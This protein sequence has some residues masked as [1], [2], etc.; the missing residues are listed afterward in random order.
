MRRLAALAIA[1]LA[2]AGTVLVLHGVATAQT[3]PPVAD[4]AAGRV[5]FAPMVGALAEVDRGSCW[6]PGG[7]VPCPDASGSNILPFQQARHWPGGITVQNGG[8]VPTRF[9]AV[10]Y[11][12]VAGADCPAC[13][14]VDERCSPAVAPGEAWSWSMGGLGALNSTT[15]TLAANVVVF[16]LNDRP[17]RDY[18]AAFVGYLEAQGLSP[19]T[20]LADLACPAI[21]Q[22]PPDTYPLAAPSAESCDR[23]L[24]FQAAY[25]A[26]GQ[27]PVAPELPMAPFRGEPIAGVAASPIDIVGGAIPHRTL[28]RYALPGLAETG[29]SSA[30]GG[31]DSGGGGGGEA[32]DSASPHVYHAPGANLD[33][34]D[35]QTSVVVLQNVG[36]QCATVT[37][38]AYET[39]RGPVEG[40]PYV[41]EV[42][43][44]GR[45]AVDV[46]T[47]WPVASAATIQV[48]S[49]EPL[50]VLQVNRGPVTSAA[51]PAVRAV[52][53]RV[54]WALPLA[55]QEARQG[56]LATGPAPV[57]EGI[58]PPGVHSV[59]AGGGAHR[60]AVQVGD[61]RRLAAPTGLRQDEG[62][63]TYLSVFN[64][65][66]DTREIR[67]RTQASGKPAREVL[68]P[69][70]GL[71]Q[72]VF[73]LGFGLGLPGGPG[74]GRFSAAGPNVAIAA[75]TQRTATDV[76]VAVLESWMTP[77]WAFQ[78]GEPGPRTVLLPDLGGPA[79]GATGIAGARPGTGIT[80]TLLAQVAVQNLV[81]ATARV[82]LDSYADCG[83]AGTVTRDIDPLQAIVLPVVDLPGTPVGAN[84]AVLRVL[85][86]EVAVL[87]GVM[88]PERQSTVDYEPDYASAYLG[89]RFAHELP[90][91][92]MVV[93]PTEI[94]LTLPLD[95]LEDPPVVRVSLV[96]ATRSCH[97]LRAASDQPWLLGGVGDGSVPGVVSVLVEPLLMSPGDRHVGHLTLTAEPAGATGLPEVVTVTVLGRVGPEPLYLPFTQR[98][99]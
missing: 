67:L 3:P 81:T 97:R 74:W 43:A 12:D 73:Q 42:P 19:D 84:A 53:E 83:W 71:A 20:T 46:G 34:P 70:R 94:T 44:G 39:N 88:R 36:L 33:T 68:Y 1:S 77:A 56:P 90:A 92:A 60:E 79:V 17:A 35:D 91:P 10:Y 95:A 76:R 40:D 38:S 45:R 55:Y 32:G 18:G 9:M 16:S 31:E 29:W 21:E 25:I 75:E 59:A 86:G 23:H 99:R 98:Q 78:P 14:V 89:Q 37:V 13:Q 85:A 4:T 72:T 50:A 57:A 26:G 2:V 51:S 61:W 63:G 62:F 48:A 82:A 8:P 15:A 5:L 47:L 80:T 11:G 96:H 6:M 66:S 41:I 54:E 7:P 22:D 27:W 49:D 69:L 93:S 52:A 24:A 64:P 65:I 87:E 28:D 30:V 58:E